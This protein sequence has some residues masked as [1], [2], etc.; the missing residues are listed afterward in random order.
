M[1]ISCMQNIQAEKWVLI[2]TIVISVGFIALLSQ[3]VYI[4]KTEEGNIDW[5]R[6]GHRSRYERRVEHLRETTYPADVSI[7]QSVKII[8]SQRSFFSKRDRYSLIQEPSKNN[9]MTLTEETAD[10]FRGI[11]KWNSELG[12][13]KKFLKI[14]D[15]HTNISSKNNPEDFV[16]SFEKGKPIAHLLVIDQNNWAGFGSGVAKMLVS[17]DGDFQTWVVEDCYSYSLSKEPQRDRQLSAPE[18]QAVDVFRVYE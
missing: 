13:W 14:E 17:R 8:K 5:S 6:M 12:K 7:R 18:C 11:L 10:P 3:K 16:V 9:L 15:K 4:P 1:Y 2:L